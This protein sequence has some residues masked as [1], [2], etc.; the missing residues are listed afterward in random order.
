MT[1]TDNSVNEMHPNPGL[2]STPTQIS[3]PYHSSIVTAEQ[4]YLT[5][6]TLPDLQNNQS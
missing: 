1:D 5:T 4:S 2:H 6:M 3:L